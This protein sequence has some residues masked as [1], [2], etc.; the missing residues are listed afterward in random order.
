MRPSTLL[1]LT[2]PAAAFPFASVCPSNPSATASELT[3]AP[4]PP[5]N[6]SLSCL[7]S[8]NE[9]CAY[10]SPSTRSPVYTNASTATNT[11][12]PWTPLAA[13]PLPIGFAPDPTDNTTDYDMDLKRF[14]KKH[15]AWS[16]AA[17]RERTPSSY[18]RVATNRNA[19][20]AHRPLSRSPMKTYSAL[21][22]GKKCSAFGDRCRSFGLFKE[23][24]P[25]CSQGIHNQCEELVVAAVEMCELYERA[26]RK[27]DVCF[28]EFDWNLGGR[29]ITRAVRAFNGYNRYWRRPG[30]GG[31][32]MEVDWAGEEGEGGEGVDVDV[33]VLMSDGEQVYDG[34]DEQLV[35]DGDEEQVFDTDG[36]EE[37]VFNTDDDE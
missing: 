32:K 15:H 18:T 10:T 13:P 9:G 11:T 35:G 20:A 25:L 37:Q 36:D 1:A 12:S 21:E 17:W 27:E 23:R 31:R 14:Q 7:P 5:S 4:S 22:C 2:G 29:R 33:D 8:S 3:S 24:V 6:P 30:K 26:L 19:S 16:L 28:G 34:D